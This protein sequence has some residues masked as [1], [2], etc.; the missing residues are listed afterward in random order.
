MCVAVAVKAAAAKMDMGWDFVEDL[1]ELKE[2]FNSGGVHECRSMLERKRDDWKTVAL[3]VAVIGNS[4]VGKS[5][6]I[7][8][9]RGLTADDDCGAAVGVTEC[10]VA[11]RSF[12]HPCNHLLQFWDLPGVGTDRFPRETYLSDIYVDRYDFFLLITADRF[13]QIDTWLGAEFRARNKKYFFVRT[14]IGADVSNNRK[15]H[16]KTH[17]EEAVVEEIRESTLQHLRENGCEDVSVFLIDSYKLKKFDFEQ[18][19]QRLVEDFPKLK[20]RALIMSLQ[21]T[22]DE[23]ISLKVAELRSR[24]WKVAALSGA[25]AAIPVPGVSMAFDIGLVVEEADVYYTQLGL[26]EL[27]L[28]RYAKLTSCDYR[29]LR[30]VVDTRL[31]CRVIG[32]EGVKKLIEELSKRAPSF[33][34]SAA[35][36]ETSRFVPIIGSFV[37]ATLSFGGTYY[38]LRLVLNKMESVAREVVKSAAD[39]ATEADLSDED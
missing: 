38:A 34:A 2:A 12:P 21:A 18:L 7:N 24:M 39:G 35:I 23:M 14:K 32:V 5:S 15:A 22:S 9:I 29:Q 31:G 11:I 8:A 4:G 28:K 25:V 17:S 16:P 30:T 10:T 26:D 1:D 19:E 6:F 36:E 27:S 37:S 13:T 33:L 20:K 3:N